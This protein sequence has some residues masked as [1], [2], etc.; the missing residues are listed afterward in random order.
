[1]V[2]LTPVAEFT[3]SLISGNAIAETIGCEVI[4][5]ETIS[6]VVLSAAWLRRVLSQLFLI[7]SYVCGVNNI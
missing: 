3:G 1:V 2:G 6:L 4:Q 5:A 7:K